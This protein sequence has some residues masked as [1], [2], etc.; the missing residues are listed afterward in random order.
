MQHLSQ[1]YINFNKN[2]YKNTQL[3][4]LEE[5]TFT[6]SSAERTKDKKQM[7]LYL[8]KM[9]IKTLCVAS[10]FWQRNKLPPHIFRP[11]TFWV[12][13]LDRHPSEVNVFIMSSLPSLM[14][15]NLTPVIQPRCKFSYQLLCESGLLAAAKQLM[16]RHSEYGAAMLIDF[17][18]KI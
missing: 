14:C 16:R 17:L 6:T 1:I 10:Y 3:C 9:D 11:N 7:V 4:L 15:S 5:A 18:L 2:L 13:K 8:Y 12:R